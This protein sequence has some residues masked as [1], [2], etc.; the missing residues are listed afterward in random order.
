M[1]LFAALENRA[2]GVARRFVLKRQMALPIGGQGEN[3]TVCGDY[4]AIGGVNPDVRPGAISCAF[5]G[6]LGN[7]RRRRE[8]HR[9]RRRYR[10]VIVIVDIQFDDTTNRSVE[11]KPVAE[12]VF[13]E[14]LQS[15]SAVTLSGEERAD[16]PLVSVC[17][18]EHDPTGSFEF[19]W[20]E[21][22]CEG[23]K[24]QRKSAPVVVNRETNGYRGRQVEPEESL[25]FAAVEPETKWKLPASIRAL[26]PF[27]LLDAEHRSRALC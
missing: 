5:P 24:L 6:M 26:I 12:L 16:R 11:T 21:S 13:G 3:E 2:F 8:C 10:F 9:R 4:D 22:S 7:D 17:S 25:F 1:K 18:L 14:A 19:R 27:T 23:L 20:F 15:A